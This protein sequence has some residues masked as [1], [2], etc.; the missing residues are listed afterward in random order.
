VTDDRP[1]ASDGSV[2]PP[3]WTLLSNHGHVLVCLAL[4]PEVRM[5]DIATQVGITERAVQI[6]IRD[7][8]EAGLVT[9][10]KVGR[11]NRYTLVRSQTFRHPLEANVHIG[12]FTDLVRAGRP[13][14]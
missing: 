13:D 14:H 8:I 5:R 4:D 10:T 11:R 3:A 9:A 12:A 1:L 2:T 7:L 6:I